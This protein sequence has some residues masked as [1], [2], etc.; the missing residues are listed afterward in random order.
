MKPGRA[1]VEEGGIA[2]EIPSDLCV[3]DAGT[4]FLLVAW[5]LQYKEVMMRVSALLCGLALCLATTTARAGF[6]IDGNK[7]QRY[8]AAYDRLEANQGTFND[9]GDSAMAIGYI[10]GVSDA[11]QGA[12]LCP[13]P[14]V[15]ITQEIAIVEK[16]L[17]EHPEE[18]DQRAILIIS[19]ALVSA[20]PCK[21][22]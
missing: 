16:Y 14:T 9:T 21:H 2:R 5:R 17:R 15:D 8:L 20:F 19:K 7:L 1:N 11:F 4:V 18:R 12:L 22:K 10:A 3:G 13:P 6:N